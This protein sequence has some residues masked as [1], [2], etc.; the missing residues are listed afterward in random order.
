ME[1]KTQEYEWGVRCEHYAEIHKGPVSEQE[2]RDWIQERIDEGGREGSF[3]L[4][5]RPVG[6][7]EK[8]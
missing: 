7:W 8:V 2:A 3:I 4:V 1:A 6:T 5:R